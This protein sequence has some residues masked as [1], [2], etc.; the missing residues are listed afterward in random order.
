MM[1]Y[2]LCKCNIFSLCNDATYYMSIVIY[3]INTLINL[4]IKLIFSRSLTGWWNLANS[5]VEPK[6]TSDCIDFMSETVAMVIN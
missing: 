1:L 3:N 5:A 4:F 6:E 2:L